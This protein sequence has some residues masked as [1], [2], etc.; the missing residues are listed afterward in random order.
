MM[1]QALTRALIYAVLAPYSNEQSDV[2]HR[3][4]L[5]PNLDKIGI[6]KYIV[7]S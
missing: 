5:D 2:M 6:F 7:I 3:I 4:R 1:K